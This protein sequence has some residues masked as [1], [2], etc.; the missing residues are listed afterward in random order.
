MYSFVLLGYASLA[1]SRTL[2]QR[3]P[4]CLNFNLESE[5]LSFLSTMAAAQVAENNGDE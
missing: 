3:L 4:A 5:D 2:S 1:A